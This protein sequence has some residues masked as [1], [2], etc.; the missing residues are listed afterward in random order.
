MKSKNKKSTEV[1]KSK[2]ATSH[3]TKN[4]SVAKSNTNAKGNVL[5]FKALEK[6]KPKAHP[7]ANFIQ[8][9][10]N[11]NKFINSAFKPTMQNVPYRKKAS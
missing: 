5:A 10:Q 4:K 1:K 7:F 11:E 3:K 2:S 6:A 9:K 8:S